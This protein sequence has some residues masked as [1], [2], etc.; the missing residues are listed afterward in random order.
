M[1][2]LAL[3][4]GLIPPAAADTVPPVF[5]AVSVADLNASVKWYGDHLD[6]TP[7]R[8]PGTPQAKVA[9]LQGKG[10]VVEL[11]QHSEAFDLESRLPELQKRYLVHG[12]FKVGFYVKDLDATVDRL[13]KRGATFKGDVFTD[14]VLGARSV[15]LLDNS[16]NVIQLFE[17]L[18]AK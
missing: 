12:L 10:L 3:F 5:F 13:K 1:I 17:R 4:V 16:G 9:L 2:L 6:L 18:G 7:T 11:V 15:L 14:K 8:L